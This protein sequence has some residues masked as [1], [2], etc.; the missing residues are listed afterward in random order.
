MIQEERF[1]E[2]NLIDVYLS[3]VVNKDEKYALKMRHKLIRTMSWESYQQLFTPLLYTEKVDDKVY[4]IEI[5]GSD[6]CKSYSYTLPK[7]FKSTRDVEKYLFSEYNCEKEV[8]EV[9]NE[10][11]YLINGDSDYLWATIVEMEMVE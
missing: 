5:Y 3:K 7:V 9:S 6:V 1:Q 10:V 2:M 11:T 8:D 4:C